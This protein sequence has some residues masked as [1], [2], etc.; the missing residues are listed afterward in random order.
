M[1]KVDELKK[2]YKD[3]WLAIEVTKVEDGEAVEGKLVL[4]SK[5]R[6]EVWKRIRLSRKK[7]IFVTFAGP[8]LEKGYAAAFLCE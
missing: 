6:D 5:D 8:P 2:R 1:A 3:Q 4:H 7:E